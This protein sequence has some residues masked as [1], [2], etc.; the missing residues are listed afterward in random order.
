MPNRRLSVTLTLPVRMVGTSRANLAHLLAI[1][2]EPRQVKKLETLATDME[3][4]Y[5]EMGDLQAEGLTTGWSKEH[6]VMP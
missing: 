4:L 3:S 1:T 2:P 5:D 6:L